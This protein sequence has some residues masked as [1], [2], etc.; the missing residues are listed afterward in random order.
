M[1]KHTNS[2]RANWKQVF[3]V[4]I[5]FLMI[6]SVAAQSKQATVD[7]NVK[8][9][10][11]FNSPSFVTIDIAGTIYDRV[12]LDDCYPAGSAGEPKIPSKG[13]FLL[14]PPDSQVSGIEITTGEKIILGSGFNVEPTS[15][16]IP[17]S[18]TDN[19]PIPTP[20]PA[21]YQS[22]AAYPGKLFTQVGVQYFRGYQILVLLLHP[23][24]YNPVTGE[25]F[26]YTSLEV[27]VQTTP[28]GVQSALYRGLNQDIQ[29]VQQKVDNPEM[30]LAYDQQYT[31]SPASFEDY[32]LLI[33]TTDALKSGFE[34]LAEAHTATGVATVIKTLT[35]IGGSD[36]ESIRN[37][38]RDAYTNWGVEYV[39]I[40]GDSDVIPAPILW[41]SGMDENVTYYED[42]MP[43]DLYYACLDGPYNY[44]NDGYW[45]EPHDG[46]DGGDVDLIAEVYV[47]RACVGSTTEVNN[48]VT[49]TV[50]YINRDVNDPYLKKICLAAE[51]L[52]DYGIASYGGTYMDQLVNGSTDDGY[53]TVGI[54]SDDYVINK[55]YDSPGYDW[56]PSAIISVIN[57]GVHAI[58]HLGHANEVYN[59]KLDT[60]DVDGLTN[61][62]NRTC[63]IYS[64]GCIAGAFDYS[65]CIAEH[66][67]IKTTH[68]AFAG[69]W[70]ARYGFFWSYSTDGDS[71]RL[72][73][74]FWDAVFGE[75]IPEI[76]RANHDSKEDNLPI[77]GRSCIRWCYYETNLFGDP[78]L[79][80]T[81][82]TNNPPATPSLPSGPTSGKI[83]IDYTFSSSTT[84]PDTGAQLFYQWSWGNEESGWLGPYESGQSIQAIHQWSTAG[85]Y[86]VKVRAKDN[87]GSMSAWSDSITI[88]IVEGPQIEIG[89]ISGG[90]KITAEIKNTGI[91][92]ASHVNWSITLQGLVLFGQEKS[93]TLLGISPGDSLDVSTGLILG[94][95][96][97][98]IT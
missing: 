80:I 88:Q 40:G 50:A 2:K 4:S 13:V 21:I 64:Q 5:A 81:E 34:A 20:N 90:M 3:I 95:G 86:Q 49:K 87:L 8:R 83:G 72:H 82:I 25:L 62:S 10:Y 19:I 73:R 31:S 58:N 11:S 47:G 17:I 53:T 23:V 30:T 63:F 59:M 44:D 76:G 69:I 1:K 84:D 14:L 67:T 7:P 48:F 41:V 78:A 16:A 77:I 15:Q 39:L 74:Q 18:Q 45:G 65:D 51:Y 89:T 28:S 54:S 9:T 60:S 94:L 97:V 93:G 91:V 55:L 66:F 57:N 37:Y 38:I 85:D 70:N 29:Q 98:D 52:G 79:K 46:T 71:Q 96:T 75:M 36:L 32:D 24:Q 6:C 22:N 33:I 61:P 92:D 12:T 35:D 56:P 26:Y 27:S 42:T 43:A 68:A